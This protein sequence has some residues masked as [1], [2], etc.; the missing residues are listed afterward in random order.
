MRRGTT[1]T[2]TISTGELDLTNHKV[3]LTYI[4]SGKVILERTNSDDSLRITSASIVNTISQTE[5]YLF[6]AGA[7]VKA[8]L[9]WI[10]ANGVAGASNIFNFTVEDVLKEGE[11]SYDTT[12]D[13]SISGEDSVQ[14]DSTITLTAT[15]TPLGETVDWSSSDETV[16]TVEDG[17]VTGVSEGTVT[18]T[19]TLHDHS[20]ISATKTITVTAAG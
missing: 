20:S 15:T 9:R 7:P 3:Y 14:E 5:S 19:A 13:I 8:Q 18:I 2:H 12:Y 17:V 6:A 10:D 1:A 16:A 11:I 4:Q